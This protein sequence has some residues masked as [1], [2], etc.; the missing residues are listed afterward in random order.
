MN[1]ESPHPTTQTPPLILANALGPN[2]PSVQ[3]VR[4]LFYNDPPESA[5]LIH[6]PSIRGLVPNSPNIDT[7]LSPSLLVCAE[8]FFEDNPLIAATLQPRTQQKYSTALEN[9]RASPYANLP[10]NFPLDH[11]LCLYIQDSFTRNPKPGNRQEM[12]NLISVIHIMYPSL[13]GANLGLSKR[14]ISGWR[15]LRPAQ[16]SAPF[17][18]SLTLALSWTLLVGGFTPAAVTLVTT[19]CGCLRVSEALALRL[20]D[21]ALPGDVRLA[22]YGPRTAGLN[23]RDAKTSRY[24]G[25]LQFV[26]LDDIDAVTLLGLWKASAQRSSG[27]LIQLSYQQYSTQLKGALSSLGLKDAP[28]TSHSARIG[29]ATQDYVSGIPIDQIAVNGR[30]K[31]LNSLRYYVTNGRAWLLDTAIPRHAQQRI[32]EAENN[33]RILMGAL[34]TISSHDDN[35]CTSQPG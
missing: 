23:V 32:L 3:I 34:P 25:R 28:F 18:K 1:R 15:A 14:C 9:F 4:R 31:S 26:K 7:H 22:S 20:E 29:K 13:R 19:Y 35:I 30:W 27:P 17:T 11:S 16:S 33:M 2:S 5:P 24:T 10:R 21:I 12:V 8:D 6:N